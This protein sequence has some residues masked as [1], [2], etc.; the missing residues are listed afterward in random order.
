MI[1]S[2]PRKRPRK[3]DAAGEIGPA[4]RSDE[5]PQPQFI[6]WL[7]PLDPGLYAFSLAADIVRREPATGLALPAIQVCAPPHQADTLE[8]TDSFGRTGSWLGGHRDVL[9]VKSPAGSAVL[10]TAY[11][12]RDPDSAPL[13][14]E[15]RRVAAA[16][17]DAWASLATSGTAA[18]LNPLMRLRL[19]VPAAA[20]PTPQRVS[21]EVVAHIRGRGDVRFVDAPW[22]GRLG[23][24]MWIEALTIVPRDPLA[25]EAIEYKGL[26][27][28]GAETPWLVSGSLCGTTGQGVP[29]VGLA[30]RQKAVA[31]EALFD[32]EYAGYF[33]SGA[34]SGPSRNGAP[35]R[36]ALDNDPLEGL[37]LRITP[38]PTRSTSS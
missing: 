4:A 2:V 1:A 27:A 8:I 24:G 26:T 28:S 34:T 23:P 17:G 14:L 29:L 15:I 21:I 37:Q 7:V 36:S 33:R 13:D 18:P 9:F 5:S 38:R 32:C 22:I 30:V 31:G 10:V 6:A 16:S 11:L 12:P 19:G 3:K 25:A 35:C 20:A